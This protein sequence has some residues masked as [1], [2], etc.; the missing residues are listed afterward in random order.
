M[1]D[2]PVG[3]LHVLRNDDGRVRSQLILRSGVGVVVVDAE[4]ERAG[5]LEEP[6]RARNR[7]EPLEGF[8]DLVVLANVAD[9][10]D[11]HGRHL[12]D[13]RTHLVPPDRVSAEL[14]AEPAYGNN[15]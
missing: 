12:F 10:A 6:G 14:A 2:E 11:A 15:A 8:A 7:A 1:L 13:L 9:G 5:L 3:Q 4:H